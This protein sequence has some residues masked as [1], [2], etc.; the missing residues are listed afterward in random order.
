MSFLIKKRGKFIAT[1]KTTPG[2]SGFIEV[3]SQSTESSSQPYWS[4]LPEPN[5]PPIEFLAF[6]NEDLLLFI[7]Q[8]VNLRIVNLGLKKHL[9]H[10]QYSDSKLLGAGVFSPENKGFLA[11]Q[12]NNQDSVDIL[13][14]DTKSLQ[15]KKIMSIPE[16]STFESATVLQGFRIA[17][18]LPAGTTNTVNA[19]DGFIV[20]DL[21]SRKYR[22]F[23]LTPSPSGLY[24]P[25]P[26]AFS[27]RLNLGIR[28]SYNPIE[29]VTKNGNRSYLAKVCLFDLD[30]GTKVRTITARE[31]SKQ[32]MFEDDDPTIALS[33]FDM[34]PYSEDY[35][36]VRDE[37]LERFEAFRFCHTEDAFWVS[38]QHG[39]IR[40]IALNGD[41]LS[42]LIAHPGD[43]KSYSH[44]PLYRTSF[45]TPLNLSEDD[46]FLS[47]GLPH[48]TFCPDKIVDIRLDQLFIIS[49]SQLLF[50]NLRLGVVEETTFSW[51]IIQIESLTE[52]DSI[53]KA[54]LQV[55]EISANIENFHDGPFLRFKFS[56]ENQII[57]EK[58]FFKVAIQKHQ[59][60]Q[61]VNEII[62]NYIKFG[63]TLWYDSSTPA[64]FYAL[65]PLVTS[66][67]Q[68]INLMVPY[69]SLMTAPKVETIPLGD[70]IDEIIKKYGWSNKLVDLILARAH[71]NGES[72]LEHLEVILK[73]PDFKLFISNP[74]SKKYFQQ[75]SLFRSL[76]EENFS[77]L[78]PQEDALF[79]AIEMEDADLA[80]ELLNDNLNLSLKH[81]EFELTAFELAFESGNKEIMQLLVKSGSQ[82]PF[83]DPQLL[84]HLLKT[85]ELPIYSLDASI[86]Q[87]IKD[88]HS[89]KEQ[90]QNEIHSIEF[91]QMIRLS[92][93]DDKHALLE[94]KN[95]D[96]KKI[97]TKI[98]Y[99]SLGLH[100]SDKILTKNRS[101][102][103]LEQSKLGSSG[104]NIGSENYITEK[105]YIYEDLINATI[106]IE[107]LEENG[108]IDAFNQMMRL[109]DNP[110]KIINNG[111]LRYIFKYRSDFLSEEE[112][113]DQLQLTSAAAASLAKFITKLI[114]LDTVP[115]WHDEETPGCFFAIQKLSLYNEEHLQLL[116]QYLKSEISGT[117]SLNCITDLIFEIYEQYEWSESTIALMAYRLGC[118]HSL[119]CLG[120]FR[121][122]WKKAGL[123]EYIVK[124]DNYKCF[125]DLLEEN[126][127]E[128]RIE[129]VI[130][131]MNEHKKD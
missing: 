32:D 93:T 92:L 70:L 45:D 17:A 1:A 107:D 130:Q 85:N 66:E 42:P 15:I 71:F 129:W 38:F 34:P 95:E 111:L 23:H 76:A 119:Q 53:K 106:Y 120:E 21:D 118:E 24:T 84:D 117:D 36:D 30:T 123:R 37:F 94:Q 99:A 61:L 74:I 40:K 9:S 121:M 7:D 114:C 63:K 59:L 43:N 73:T 35:Q 8:R 19:G 127:S 113:F 81:P 124:G 103:P 97:Q 2:N 102:N 75:H 10:N 77:L 68:F 65:Y 47:F 126:C 115:L 20:I 56:L 6:I 83:N 72:G 18:Y 16:I 57:S 51:N 80:E 58:Q 90:L 14:F 44:D 86:Q 110:G 104:K 91:E 122:H 41:L 11:V 22:L 64:F 39:L 116:R 46:R 88:L 5:N 125:I 29:I 101:V 62:V 87:S 131:F 28:P 33:C 128:N 4:Y 50:Q 55:L 60:K 48:V 67:E 78:Y 105:S 3:F 79:A 89:K 96:L 49:E 31:F 12:S 27:S 109:L 54:L 100:K 108:Q 69:M 13:E 112:F 25:P 52:I 82:L 26:V 98:K